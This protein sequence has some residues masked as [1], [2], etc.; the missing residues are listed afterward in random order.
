MCNDVAINVGFCHRFNSVLV[1]LAWRRRERKWNEKQNGVCH[2]SKIGA[3]YWLRL[4]FQTIK[5][6]TAATMTSIT[7]TT[8]TA[9]AVVLLPPLSPLELCAEAADRVTPP[10]IDWMLV[11]DT[12]MALVFTFSAREVASDSVTVS[13]RT[14][15]AIIEPQVYSIE[16]YVT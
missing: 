1:I 7:T 14:T 13:G 11:P 9:I 5:P 10:G 2:T 12:V 16:M 15:L 8:A 6:M 3:T 4:F